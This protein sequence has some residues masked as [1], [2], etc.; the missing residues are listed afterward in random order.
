MNFSESSFRN[1]I[2]YKENINTL[3]NLPDGLKINGIEKFIKKN[4]KKIFFIKDKSW[5][6]ENEFKIIDNKNDYL[7]ISESISA[8]YLSSSKSNE[9]LMVKK[10]VH[11]EV[12]V[13]YLSYSKSNDHE[14]P[15][16]NE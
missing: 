15:Y 8:I 1:T 12:P 10:I 3:I 16:I 4:N 6:K 9:Y 14:F 5:S 7:D 2:T 13:R 11:D